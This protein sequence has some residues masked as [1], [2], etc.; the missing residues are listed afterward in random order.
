[1]YAAYYLRIYK[2][3]AV[4]QMYRGKN[5]PKQ[6]PKLNELDGFSTSGP[7]LFYLEGLKEG[8]G[9]GT[10]RLMGPDEIHLS[11][12]KESMT[13]LFDLDS[14]KL[15]AHFAEIDHLDE[16]RPLVIVQPSKSLAHD[17]RYVVALVGA[18]D[19]NG[20]ELPQ[21]KHLEL[22]MRLDE[23]L[24]SSE[25]RRG[26]FYVEEIIPSMRRSIQ[27]FDDIKIIQ[28]LFDFHTTSEEG[29]LGI[30][31]KVMQGTLTKLFSADEKNHWDETNV[32]SI[33]EIN[34]D[35]MKDGVL[36]ARTV[37]ASIDIPHFLKDPNSRVTNLD[38]EAVL[39]GEPKGK[40]NVKFLVTIPCSLALGSKPLK[41]I[42]DYGHGFLNSR[43]E[44]LDRTFLHR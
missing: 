12:T 33:E 37:H 38:I 34:N 30:T 44:L 11:T 17:R 28:M 16:S 29:Q 39:K 42:V 15:V 22:L 9:K 32:H 24:S 2:V 19:D 3:D 26:K 7:I 36:L 41:A 20:N 10:N 13:L 21:S 40:Y 35:C 43:I 4:Q 6:S 8:L 1:M 5:T 14:L 25:R 31:R 27:F 18:T 23:K